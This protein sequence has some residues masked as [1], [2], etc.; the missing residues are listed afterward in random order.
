[1]RLHTSL[2]CALM[3]APLVAAPAQSE[4]DL[5]A[6]VALDAS[7]I[8]AL[9]PLLSPSMVGR[10][11]NG[12]Q[13]GIRYGFSSDNN[14]TRHAVAGSGIFAVGTNSSISLTAGVSDTDC[15][16]C[17]LE[18]LLGVGG[19]MRVFE[20][21]DVLGQ[22]NS[23]SLGVSGDFGFARLQPSDVNAYA[24]G[25]GAPMNLTIAR[26][27]TTG[28][29]IVAYFTPML[30]IGQLSTDC[31]TPGCQNSG[32][33]WVMGGGIGVWNPLT[34]ISASVG[35]NRVMFDDAATTFGVNVVLG[36]R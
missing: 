19:D 24:L 33:R 35:F 26:G 3:I 21:G 29:R 32:T 8:G 6:F 13:L 16:D 11:L 20:A 25:I 36:G 14:E 2:L 10:Q 30:G 34:S 18:L 4:G 23:F 27:G 17:T 7:P 28:M 1:M 5:R 15:T 9:T 12:A 22:G 31:L